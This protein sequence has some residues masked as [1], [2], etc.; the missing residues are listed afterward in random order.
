MEVPYC[1]SN[2]TS[3]T[4]DPSSPT[5]EDSNADSPTPLHIQI[6]EQE[7][8]ALSLLPPSR[9]ATPVIHHSPPPSEEEE[10]PQTTPTSSSEDDK[11]DFP[12]G[13]GWFCSKPGAHTTCLTIP[14]DHGDE[15]MV[16][17]KYLKFT[18]NY[19]SEP[20]IEATMGWGHPHYALPITA[21]PT[22][23][24]LSPP[25]NDEEE[26]AFL[27]ETHMMN[28]TLNRALEGL[29]DYGVYA[30]I[31]RLRNGR[32]QMNKLYSQSSHIEALEVFARQQRLRYEHQ[33]WEH[34]LSCFFP[35]TVRYDQT[36]PLLTNTYHLS[37]T[38]Q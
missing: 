29:G 38:I 10:Q 5:P 34:T 15:E 6:L 36:R 11:D 32:Q 21:S 26:L 8:L 31:I 13:E 12:I 37:L 23:K 33:Q 16:D 20:T 25:H 1:T 7:I 24:C 18:I 2:A 3:P 14:P 35:L 17:A 4:I 28:S 22:D 27:A 19:N 9:P 30:N